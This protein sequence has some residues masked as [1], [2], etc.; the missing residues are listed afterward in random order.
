MLERAE[1]KRS[2]RW[3]TLP[4]L[5]ELL[6]RMSCL[7]QSIGLGA[8]L[9][10][11]GRPLKFDADERDALFSD[12]VLC[13]NTVCRGRAIDSEEIIRDDDDKITEEDSPGW[14][15]EGMTKSPLSSGACRGR[16]HY[17]L[18]LESLRNARERGELERL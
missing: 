2:G 18:G 11:L 13:N 14:I 12:P 15:Y 8:P 10:A 3:R 4:A 6:D 17:R 1:S 5:E 16:A 7:F 9:Y